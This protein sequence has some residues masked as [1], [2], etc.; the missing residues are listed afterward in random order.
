MTLTFVEE[1]NSNTDQLTQAVLGIAVVEGDHVSAIPQLSFHSRMSPTT[2]THCIYNLGIGIILQGD[3][4][5]SE[6]LLTSERT[7]QRLLNKEQT[8]F[9]ILATAVRKEQAER[10]LQ[11]SQLPIKE[12]AYR[13]GYADIS[14]FSR[15][16]KKWTNVTPK[17]YREAIDGKF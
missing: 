12:I 5:V 6:K 8:T 3:K 1:R 2:S 9:Q 11:Q 16:F 13:L 14:H 7:L 17:F 15:A 4:E 10:L